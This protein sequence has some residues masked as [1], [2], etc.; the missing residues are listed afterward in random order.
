VQRRERRAVKDA[1]CLN[2]LQCGRARRH[3]QHT[4]SLDAACD[5]QSARELASGHEEVEAGEHL[6]FELELASDRVVAGLETR[7][8]MDH[9]TEVLTAGTPRQ[10][11]RAIEVQG[12]EQINPG[13]A[14]AE[15]GLQGVAARALDQREPLER[16]QKAEVVEITA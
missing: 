6:A 4:L 8:V 7:Q 15:P 14:L 1:R 10:P 16:R 12:V 5:Q 3:G 11:R 13:R 2:G 9:E